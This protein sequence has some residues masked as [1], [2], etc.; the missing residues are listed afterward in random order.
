MNGTKRPRALCM[1]GSKAI[2]EQVGE[3]CFR[4][5]GIALRKERGGQNR[6]TSM[7]QGVKF[8]GDA[9][10][11]LTMHAI[12]MCVG[13]PSVCIGQA[14]TDSNILRHFFP[15]EGVASEHR[16]LSRPHECALQALFMT[17]NPSRSHLLEAN[18]HQ[19][20]VVA[21]KSHRHRGSRGSIVLEA[22]GDGTH[23]RKTIQ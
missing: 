12:R 19:H 21:A 13:V 15:A 9:G 5:R 1:G 8:S 10:S 2:G 17:H 18:T 16:G 7:H 20:S 22:H 11:R 23:R 4:E 6:K 3:T 14:S